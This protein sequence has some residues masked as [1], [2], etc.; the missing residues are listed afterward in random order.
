MKGKLLVVVLVCAAVS[1]LSSQSQPNLENGWK[2]FGSYDGSHLDTVN[3]MNGNLM[4]HALLVP[5]TPQ[6][7][8]IKISSLLYGTFKDWQ[9]VCIPGKVGVA[10]NW[11]KGGGSIGINST[12]NLNVHRTLNK[13]YSSGEGITTF[14]AY[15]YTITSPDGSTHQLHGVAGTEDVNGQPTQFDVIDLSGY[16][17]ALSVP[18]SVYTTVLSHITVTDRSGIQYQGDFDPVTDCGR[19][20][21]TGLSAPGNHPPLSDD[22]PAGDQYCSQLAYASLVTDS[23]GN[24]ISIFGPKNI[25]PTTDTLGKAPPFNRPINVNQ[26]LVGA[27]GADI[28]GCS[29]P[30]AISGAAT[31]D[32]QDPNGVTRQL[33]LCTAEIQIATN[34]QQPSPYTAGANVTEAETSTATGRISLDSRGHGSPG[35]WLAL[36][37]RL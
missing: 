8:A 13:Q 12:P 29:S 7:G 34:F 2:P 3:L 18:D 24:Q 5:D 16:H 27:T 17:L 32:Y 33:K 26:A 28:T 15:G 35:G 1:T 30:H 21:R 36:H 9:V 14:A 11:Q 23:N 10:C 4:F 20:Q 22:T 31:Y 37:L 25:N 19:I 6:R